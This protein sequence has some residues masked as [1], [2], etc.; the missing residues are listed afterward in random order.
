MV[1][2]RAT[3]ELQMLDPAKLPLP[4]LYR[5]EL[6]ARGPASKPRAS[7]RRNV[8][9]RAHATNYLAQGLPCVVI[10]PLLSL[11]LLLRAQRRHS[12]SICSTKH[13]AAGELAFL[14]SNSRM[15]STWAEYHPAYGMDTMRINLAQLSW[16]FR[17]SDTLSRQTANRTALDF[18]ALTCFSNLAT[19][20]LRHVKRWAGSGSSLV[21]T[22]QTGRTHRAV[23]K[24]ATL[25]CSSAYSAISFHIFRQSWR[26]WRL[27]KN[28]TAPSPAIKCETCETTAKS[29]QAQPMLGNECYRLCGNFELT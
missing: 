26:S 8:R 1:V 25:S 5:G 13:V 2:A 27:V 29:G 12:R 4:S 14:S 15:A 9:G 28:I 10:V 21:S 19:P 16:R 22:R 24:T 7:V 3:N 20:F 18:L 23:S 11:P 17:P 6:L